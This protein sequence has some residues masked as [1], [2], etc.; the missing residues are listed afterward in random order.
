MLNLQFK[1]KFPKGGLACGERVVDPRHQTP[2]R[3]LVA[4]SLLSHKDS[5]RYQNYFSVS[6]ITGK[7]MDRFSWNFHEIHRQDIRN[8]LENL[9]GDMFNPLH[10]GFLFIFFQG[11]PCLLATLRQ[12]VWTDFHDF[13]GKIGHGT[14]TIWN[15][16]RILWLTAWIRY[17]LFYFL[18]PCLVVI[19]WKNG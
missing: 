8:N 13:L 12:N 19:L 3:Q 4:K 11:N 16:F 18:D 5:F 15:I 7:H 1:I 2:H 9:R 14:R 17:R 10:T 6:N